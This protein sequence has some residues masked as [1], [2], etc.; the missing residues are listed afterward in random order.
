MLLD[1]LQNLSSDTRFVVIALII[2]IITLIVLIVFN[3]TANRIIK[4]M[5]LKEDFDPTTYRFVQH[6]VSALIIIVALGFIIWMIPALRYIAKSLV[7]GAGIAAVI[8]GFASQAA[9]ANVISGLFIVISKP[10]R[11]K[12]RIHVKNELFGTVEDITLRH[13][14]IRNYENQR[15]IIPNSIMNSEVVTNNDYEE[16]RICKW[17]YVSISY[18]ADIDKAKQVFREECEK[19]PK[20]IDVR[21][22]EDVAD[23]EE[24]VRVKV[25]ELGE[26]FVKLKAWA[27]TKN[28]EDSFE[29]GWDVLENVKKA[30]DKAGIEIPFP[31]RTVV[32]KKDMTEQTTPKKSS[33]D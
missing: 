16:D 20:V 14:V 4:R 25:V 12:D 2:I 6:T 21:T 9:L 26:Y 1:L 11:I 13:T 7:A 29:V 18:D 22:P 5:T 24:K 19:H 10:Y 28:T 32:Y 15:I 3:R 33:K 23:G 30:Y 31:Y 8:I 27:W 17:L